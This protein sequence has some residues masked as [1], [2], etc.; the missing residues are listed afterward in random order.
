MIGH[1]AVSGFIN[2]PS[3]ADDNDDATANTSLDTA[4]ALHTLR[5]TT[6]LFGQIVAEQ[7]RMLHV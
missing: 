7:Q 2:Q 3:V 1:C 6:L 4:S 5:H